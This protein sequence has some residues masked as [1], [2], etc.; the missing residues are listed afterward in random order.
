MNQTKEKIPNSLWFLLFVVGTAYL[1]SRYDFQ[2]STLTIP[3]FQKSLGL[4]DKE[5]A[6]ITAWVKL[7]AIPAVLISFFADIWGRKPIFMVSI[8][9]FSIS[10]VIAA[11][12]HSGAILLVG[13]FCTRLFTMIGELLA[14]VILSESSPPG[15][16]AFLLGMVAVFGTFGDAFA[17][18]GY[19]FMGDDPDSWRKMYMIGALPIFLT[20]WWR[21]ALKETS[22]FTHHRPESFDI[23]R[24]FENLGSSKKQVFIICAALV[25]Y[26][27]P[28]S[29]A[30]SMYSKYLQDALGW[31]PSGVSMLTIIAGVVGTLGMTFGGVFADRFGRKAV[32][33]FAMIMVALGTFGMYYM[34]NQN[35]IGA[36]YSVH[37][38]GWFAF[39]VATRAL[40]TESVETEARATA[41]GLMEIFSTLGA[42]LGMQ[43]LSESIEYFGNE[44]MPIKLMTPLIFGGLVILL[45]AKETKGKVIE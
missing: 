39:V 4:S 14:V 32:S 33:I 28:V 38:V 8:I 2:L 29:P 42:Y 20:L 5:A 7:G 17:I 1:A 40:V 18:V 23:L 11:N 10:A 24:P 25:L 15:V 21:S 13:L 19:G 30:L 27:I 34:H 37:L 43:I 9:G 31:K 22:A 16:R 3:Q 26:W 36:A 12:A 44:A 45:F 6:Q 35:L 41:T